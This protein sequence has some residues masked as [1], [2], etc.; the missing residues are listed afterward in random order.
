M[1]N[2]SNLCVL[3]AAKHSINT[4]NVSALEGVEDSIPEK[5]QLCPSGVETIDDAESAMQL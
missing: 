5:E 3:F 4:S 1:Q 2:I